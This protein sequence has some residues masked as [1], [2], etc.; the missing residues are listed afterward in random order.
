[1]RRTRVEWEGQGWDERDRV[2]MR[3]TGLEW[4]G[5]GWDYK[6]SVGI[7]RIWLGWEGGVGMRRRSWNEK[8]ELEWEGRVGMRRTRMEWER[9]DLD[10]KVLMTKRG[11]IF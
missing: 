7:R 8:D 3:G 6:D 11:N 1:M 9:E 5:Q 4:E 2:G 10:E